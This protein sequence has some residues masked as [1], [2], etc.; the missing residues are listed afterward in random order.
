[1]S[2]KIVY[3]AS[4]KPFAQALRRD[5]TRQERHL[6]YDFLKPHGAAVKRQKQ[7]GAYIAGFY[8]PRA[9]LVIEIDG[10]QHFEPDG[11]TRDKKRDRY[12][13]GLGLSVLRFSNHDIDCHFASV[14]DM[15]NAELAKRT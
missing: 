9:K 10:S 12:L 1:M 4:L 14:C 6:W 15:I 13:N 5:M 3:D 11:K 2:N 8:C 7:F